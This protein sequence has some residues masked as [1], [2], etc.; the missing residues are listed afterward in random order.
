MRQQTLDRRGT[1]RSHGA[2]E[3]GRAVLILC[4]DRGS[5][6]E[7]ASNRLRLRLRIPVRRNHV[8]VRGVMQRTAMT[9]IGGGVWI[10]TGAKQ[11]PHDRDAMAGRGQMK[12]RITHIQPVIDTRLIQ[13][14][15]LNAGVH[16]AA[17][18][19]KERLDAATIVLD[20]GGQQTV[21]S[22]TF[23]RRAG[24]GL[25]RGRPAPDESWDLSL[26]IDRAQTE[27]RSLLFAVPR[28]H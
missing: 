25:K 19:V 5:R 14:C 15:F 9:M 20:D 26:E 12:R 23:S 2:M 13:R 7:Q 16:H 28:P 4:I 10:G 8:A 18:G 22:V 24:L 6:F 17:I 21:H 3:W 27:C 11:Q 1:A